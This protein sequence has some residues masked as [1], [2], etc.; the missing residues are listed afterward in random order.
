MDNTSADVGYI[1][2]HAIFK[3]HKAVKPAMATSSFTGFPQLLGCD[4]MAIVF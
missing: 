3:R 2:S 1:Y 4:V